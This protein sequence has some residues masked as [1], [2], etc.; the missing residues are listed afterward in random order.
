MNKSELINELSKVSKLTKKD[1]NL[2]LNA[3]TSVVESSLSKGENI[4]LAGF[5]KFELKN[6]KSRNSYNPY[7]KKTVK[8]PAK[9]VP[10]FRAG[11]KLKEAIS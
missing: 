1:C 8:I 3:L 4:T 5:G 6:K 7:L 9:L 10:T 2:C 11:K